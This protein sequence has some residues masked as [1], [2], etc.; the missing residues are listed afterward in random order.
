M[1]N[2]GASM[3]QT[4]RLPSYGS[5]G[6]VDRQ[7]CIEDLIRPGL[8]RAYPFPTEGCADDE[9][10]GLLLDALARRCGRPAEG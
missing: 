10:F 9:R 2:E 8:R 6:I 4:D 3:A 7:T 5:P 1:A